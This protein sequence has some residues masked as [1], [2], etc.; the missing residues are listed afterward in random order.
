MELLV[1]EIAVPFL[2]GVCSGHI[3]HR[4]LGVE[5]HLLEQDGVEEQQA[6]RRKD[7]DGL[8]L[9]VLGLA[10]DPGVVVY[11]RGPLLSHRVHL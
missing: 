5:S 6:G 11:E 2:E 3:H 4:I 7:M 9:E 1:Q 10:A 8:A